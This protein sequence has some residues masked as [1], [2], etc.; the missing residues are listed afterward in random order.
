MKLKAKQETRNMSIEELRKKVDETRKNFSKSMLD[1]K[2]FKL[3]NVRS[4][5]HMRKE[6]AVMLT[7]IK[8]KEMQNGK[9]A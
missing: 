9:N 1:H 2:Q 3:K 7:V 8:E 6:I 5:T 4:L